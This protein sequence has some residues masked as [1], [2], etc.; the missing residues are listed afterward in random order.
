M[1]I[2]SRLATLTKTSVLSPV[3]S[4]PTIALF[5]MFRANSWG[6]SPCCAMT[7]MNLVAPYKVELIAEAVEMAA[8]SAI[9][10]NPNDPKKGRVAAAKA[11]SL[12]FSILAG[13][14]LPTA[15]KTTAT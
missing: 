11:Y 9:G 15:T 2:L 8:A 1:L 5:Q 6:S 4:S 12:Y 3:A 14:R 7:K 13:S 10:V